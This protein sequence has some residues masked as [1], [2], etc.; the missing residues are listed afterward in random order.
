MTSSE[1][2]RIHHHI[3]RFL[4]RALVLKIKPNTDKMLGTTDKSERRENMAKS[5]G[6]NFDSNI[7][8]TLMSEKRF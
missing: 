7:E 8:K 2:V 6:P 3:H 4:H 5:D 1:V